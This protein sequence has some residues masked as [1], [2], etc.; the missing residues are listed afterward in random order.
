MRINRK[1]D[2]KEKMYQ[3]AVDDA[4]IKIY[5][6]EEKREKGGDCKRVNQKENESESAKERK[7]RAK[8]K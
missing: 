2:T 1:S 6:R 5:A 4:H 8:R 7:A 3:S